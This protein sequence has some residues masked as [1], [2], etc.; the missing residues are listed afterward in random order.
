M[1]KNTENEEI[2]DVRFSIR[3]EKNKDLYDDFKDACNYLFPIKP[4]EVAKMLLQKGIKY[5]YKGERKKK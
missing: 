3:K 2:I 1:K 4:N 5:W